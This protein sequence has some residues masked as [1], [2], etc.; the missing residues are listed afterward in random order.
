VDIE[1]PVKLVLLPEEVGPDTPVGGKG[2]ALWA[3]TSAGLPVPPWAVAVPEAFYESLEPA[4][5][6]ALEA[7]HDVDEVRAIIEQVRPGPTVTAGLAQAAARLC[8]GGEPMAVRSS[9]SEE[10]TAALSFAGQLESFLFV[11]ADDLADRVA[12][13]WRSGFGAR[14]LAYRQQAGLAPV[15]RAPAVLIQRMV[16]PDV[17][18]VAFS[19]DPVSGRRAVAVVA[20]VPGLA[21][22]IVSGEATADT[23]R[24]D[25]DGTIVERHVADKPLVHRADPGS[26]DGVRR[27]ELPAAQRSQP[28]LDDAGVGAVAALARDSERFFGRPQDI[29]WAMAGTELFLLQSRPITALAQKADPDDVRTVWDNANIIESYSGV[30]T[31]LTFSFARRAYEVV[32]RQFCRLMRVSPRVIEDNA[33]LFRCML[34]LV[35]GRVYYNLPSWYRL[36]ALLPGARLNRTFLEQM[37]GL[38]ESLTDV[39]P[40]RGSTGSRVRDAV[41]VAATLWGLLAAYATLGRR[42]EHFYRR[43]DRTLGHRRPDLSGRTAHELVGYYLDLE[44]RLLARWDAPL[45]NDFAA[46]FFHGMLRRLARTWIDDRD[47]TLPNDLLCGEAG[48]ISGEPAHRVREMAT[49]AAGYPGLVGLLRDGSVTAIRREMRLVPALETCYRAYLDRFGDRCME[50]LKLESPTLHDDPLPLLRAVGRLAT[51]LVERGPAAPHD[52]EEP[53][54]RQKAV[55]RVHHA[56]GRRPVRR[57]LFH[58]V[59]RNARARVRDREN[60]R[61]E[62]TRAF[63][64]ARQILTEVGRRLAALDQLG[65]P[66]DVFYLE[67]E[68][69]LSFVQARATTTDLR[70]LVALRTA[71][72]ARYRAEAA[73]ADRFETRGIAYVGNTYAM[74][75]AAPRATGATLTGLGCCAGLVRGPVRVIRDPRAVALGPGEIVVAE[76]TDPGWVMIFPAAAGLLVERGSLLSHSAIVARELGLPTIVSLS[77]LTA[78]LA[79]GDWVEMDGATGVVVKLER[80]PGVRAD[81]AA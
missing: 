80:A 18:G 41:R 59:L 37:L 14:L 40:V 28:S 49:L 75:S 43:L 31:P 74:T 51:T 46:M 21:S 1:R 17:A 27:D 60:L 52:D 11:G 34:G 81:V 50:E 58:W 25:R 19:A 23:W 65:D 35:R 30:T 79:D 53:E 20:A 77:G 67:V 7:A 32:Y 72:F 44:A 66:A 33:A 64:R 36:V 22:A 78:W 8:P 68:E 69:I 56:L 16:H 2:R 39:P 76:R 62:R 12:R 73:P 29:E 6:R 57:L 38:R 5:R 26:V 48:M 45:V 3:L 10:D 71:E 55:A 63:G 54:R 24:I 47:G 9:A 15:P 61:L 4:A 42:I 13:V 70:G